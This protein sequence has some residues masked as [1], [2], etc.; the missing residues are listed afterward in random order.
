MS[1]MKKKFFAKITFLFIFIFF[2]LSPTP[3]L[4][5]T[6]QEMNIY[7]LYLNSPEKGDCVLLESKGHALLIDIGCASY[8]PG[9]IRQLNTLGID[10]IDICFSHLHPDHTGGAS[11]DSLAGLRTLVDSGIK[12]N[13][14]YLPSKSF[15]PFSSR[16]Y[17][18]FVKIE[19][20]MQQY[21]NICYLNVGDKIHIGDVVGD[22]IGPVNSSNYTPSQY[23]QSNGVITSAMYTEYENNNSLAMIFTCGK[24]RFFTAGDCFKDEASALCSKYG[25]NLKCDIMKL[26]HH[27]TPSGNITQLIDYIQPAYSFASN[28]SF[29]GKSSETGRWKTYTATHRASKYGMCY[30][31]GT[32]KQTLIYHVVNNEITLYKGSIITASNKLTGWQH[33]YG[34]DGINMDYNT[35]YLNSDC[36]PLKGTQHLGNHYFSFDKTGLMQYGTFND[37]SSYNGWVESPDGIRY[38]TLSIDRKYSYMSVG[39]CKING[40]LYYF[41]PQGYLLTSNNEDGSSQITTINNEYYAVDDSGILTVSD[42]LESDG[43]QYY[44]GQNGKMLRNG[45]YKID[46]TY[47]IFNNDGNLIVSDSGYKKINFNNKTYVVNSEG[48]VA[49]NKCITLGKSKYYYN[50]NGIMRKNCVVKLGKHMYYF[51]KNGAMVYNKTIR[52]KGVAYKCSA[53]G[54]MKKV[55]F[56]K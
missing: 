1:T 42:W 20:F 39:F 40:F 21:T 49:A 35:Y 46:G 3:T 14:L 27:G 7:A 22:I 9:I 8:V 18:K 2:L 13:H 23:A 44:F 11:G 29:T 25:S 17:Q 32:E 24:T 50:E 34:S 56:A 19:K 26:C 31:V 30:A 38:Y 48:M 28:I 15:T 33:F 52:W 54:I 12:I 53:N 45:M 6:T 4:A 47:Y 55:S 41:N 36:M 51:G 10:E 16:Y 5:D 43:F 37:N